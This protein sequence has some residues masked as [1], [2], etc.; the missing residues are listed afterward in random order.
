M[1]FCQREG[2]LLKKLKKLISVL[3]I[4]SVIFSMSGCSFRLTSFD[5]L[6]RPPKLSGKYQGLQDSFEKS[7]NGQVVLVTP[8]N[9][10]HQSAFITADID[11]D[12]EEEA[13][14]FFLY[15][16]EPDLVKFS[17]FEY[18][19]DDWVFVN[20]YDGL[21]DSIDKV[22]ISDFNLDGFSEIV[23][24]WNLF[25]SKTNKAFTAYSTGAG[26][27]KIVGSYPYSHLEIID[28]N[29]DSINDVLA[30]T[31][32]SSVPNVLTATARF[33][34]YNIQKT[35]LVVK[36]EAPLDGNVISYSSVASEFVDDNKLIYIE[37]DKGQSESVTEIIYWDDINNVL[38]SPLFESS[39]G[40]TTS[41]WR[42][43]KLTAFDIDDDGYLE[44]PTSVKMPGASLSSSDS[45]Q[46][47]DSIGNDITSQN[48]VYYIKWVKFR[49]SSLKP[50]QYSVYNDTFKYTLNIKSSWVGR[51]T[52][53]GVDGQWDYYRYNS[54]TQSQGDLLFSI[55]AYDSSNA[56]AK[57]QFAS[58]TELASASGKTFVYHIS[59]EGYR[60]GVTENMIESGFK[61]SD[62]GGSK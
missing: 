25:S 28:V 19:E 4:L 16:Q 45:S 60:F 44:I 6:I 33:Y 14:V 39:A 8:E 38:V 50:V 37:A 24:G 46:M 57:E 26:E 43:V 61:I 12:R 49:N 10:S 56:T 53:S 1:H 59:N 54:A 34:N 13:L 17:Y 32:D 48:T 11:G 31:I 51:V 42:N 29:G 55:Y 5:N 41:T 22:E 36:G 40:S 35:A 9:G 15:R 3:L 2:D 7:V 30:L 20:T 21:G 18:K 27:L 58:Y 47:T 23:I 62:F 52:V